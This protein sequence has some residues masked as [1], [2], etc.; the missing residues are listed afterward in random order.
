MGL[1]RAVT[2]RILSHH[3]SMP[4]RTTTATAAVKRRFLIKN[5]FFSAVI[6]SRLNIV[7]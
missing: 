7:K 4:Q 6:T 1:V 2:G 3:A 5:Q